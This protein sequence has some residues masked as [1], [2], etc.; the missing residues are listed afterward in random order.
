MIK[1][2]LKDKK[3]LTESELRD[4][5]AFC[6]KNKINQKEISIICIEGEDTISKAL[7]KKRFKRT[8]KPCLKESAAQ[9]QH[10]SRHTPNQSVCIARL[11]GS[12]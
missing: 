3:Y 5:L 9:H 10:R 1:K 7:S 4:F 11:V 2:I 8:V 12:R 6:E